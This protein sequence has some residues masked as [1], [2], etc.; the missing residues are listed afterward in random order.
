MKFHYTFNLRDLS[1]IYQ[2]LCRSMKDKFD[3][4]VSIV[5]LWR[6][7]VTRTFIDKLCTLKDVEKVTDY[8]P[9]IIKDFFADSQGD[10]ADAPLIYG[11][12]ILS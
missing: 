8:I 1:N 4:K 10:D 9:D 5:K 3:T 7:E 2:G 11:D 12:F 6:N